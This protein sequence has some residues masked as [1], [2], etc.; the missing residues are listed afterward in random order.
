MLINT[1]II[2]AVLFVIS[3]CGKIK[4]ALDNNEIVLNSI[5][6]TEIRLTELSL[7]VENKLHRI[8]YLV[9]Q[10]N[11]PAPIEQ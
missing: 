10:E 2:V 5:R 9:S 4:R 11:K 3:T 8:E 7:Q 1:C 6:N